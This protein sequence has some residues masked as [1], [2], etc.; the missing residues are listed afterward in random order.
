MA[1][2]P[3]AAGTGGRIV[4]ALPYLALLAAAAA[5]WIVSG[6]IEY[7][8]RPGALGP[9]FWPRAA[10]GL[11]GLL[12]LFQIGKLLIV[13]AGR[14]AKGVADQLG[15]D[16]EEDD[17]PRRPLLLVGGIALTVAY[18]ASLNTLGFP[19]ATALFM[20][21]F[22]YLGGSRS[23]LAIWAS[24]LIGVVFVTLMLMKVVYVSLPRGAPPFDRVV[25]LITGF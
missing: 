18:A 19:L 9:D 5:L 21:L 16:E 22:M 24:S 3:A 23:H 13:G 11:I 14:E 7:S 4:A 17:A 8:A 20:I 12:C 25:D 15:A 6:R 2:P 10:I 1:Q